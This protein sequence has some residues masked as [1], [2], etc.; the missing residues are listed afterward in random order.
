MFDTFL[1]PARPKGWRGQK[2][3]PDSNKNIIFF[4]IQTLP[5]HIDLTHKDWNQLIT[6][7]ERVKLEFGQIWN[8]FQPLNRFPIRICIK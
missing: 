3:Q 2:H 4:D 8:N 6:E 1:S 5:D 7:S